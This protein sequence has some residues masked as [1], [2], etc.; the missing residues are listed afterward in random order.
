MTLAFVVAA[1]VR[2]AVDADR[3]R[4][5][6]SLIGLI[7]LAQLA[8]ASRVSSQS[9]STAVVARCA[10]CTLTVSRVAQLDQRT[11]ASEFVHDAVS[12]VQ[13]SRGRIVAGPLGG[14]ASFAVFSATGELLKV[15]GRSGAGPAEFRMIGAIALTPHDSI[16][17]M[18]QILHRLSI[19]SPTLEFVR[20]VPM[21]Q[22]RRMIAL[23]GG[24]IVAVAD[25]RSGSSVGFALHEFD[26]NDGNRIRS[27]GEDVRLSET[28]P[29]HYQESK[30]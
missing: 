7:I 9:T 14:F 16:L 28:P 13:D 24:T 21:P 17:V 12:I 29:M 30:R 11:I 6:L 3:S 18:D 26:L 15:I 2:S 1:R 27:F 19:F 5:H 25:L 20:S 8:G 4:P 10:D 23:P 22:L